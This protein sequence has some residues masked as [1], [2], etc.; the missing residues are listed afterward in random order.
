M[1]CDR[2]ENLHC[3]KRQ[4]LAGGFTNN[5][6]FSERKGKKMFGSHGREVKFSQKC[7]VTIRDPTS[8]TERALLNS[9]CC[10]KDLNLSTMPEIGISKLVC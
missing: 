9:E 4:I 5:F 3:Q 6:V 7:V 1:N 10:M 2:K 8:L